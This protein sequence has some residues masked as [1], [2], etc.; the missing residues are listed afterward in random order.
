M[1]TLFLIDGLNN[2]K[3]VGEFK[4][5]E[6][7]D[8]HLNNKEFTENW[9]GDFESFQDFKDEFYTVESDRMKEAVDK[10]GSRKKNYWN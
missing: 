3:V 10:F 5:A 6:E 1:G 4:S 7:V 9:G 2:N 8:Q